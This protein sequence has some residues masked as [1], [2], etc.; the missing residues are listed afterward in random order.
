[1][2]F[3]MF[4]VFLTQHYIKLCITEYIFIYNFKKI[5]IRQFIL[6][7][8]TIKTWTRN[9]IL[10]LMYQGEGRYPGRLGPEL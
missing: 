3:I 9:I 10:P 1:M 2:V 6:K 8:K 5:I 4:E 7:F